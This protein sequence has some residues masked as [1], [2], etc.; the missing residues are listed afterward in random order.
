M[1]LDDS[2]SL[3]NEQ[4]RLI[5]FTRLS[6]LRFIHERNLPDSLF[7]VIS[8]PSLQRL[9]IHEPYISFD[10][11]LHTYLNQNLLPSLKVLDLRWKEQKEI[12]SRNKETFSFVFSNAP[13]LDTIIIDKER[14]H[15]FLFV[16]AEVSIE[17]RCLRTLL[18]AEERADDPSKRDIVGSLGFAD[19]PSFTSYCSM[20][21]TGIN[22]GD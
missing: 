2:V 3:P 7:Q 1:I 13:I 16:V 4:T 12:Q 6:T 11:P 15:I 10:S 9:I 19:S 21:T 14:L 5:P 8:F 17:P 18:L 22:T 20:F